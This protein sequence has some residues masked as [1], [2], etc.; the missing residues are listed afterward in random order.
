MA[1]KVSAVLE[2]KGR[3]VV[4]VA[5]RD[6]VASLVKVLSVNRIGAAPVVNADGRL[7]G[8]ISERDVIR[9]MAQHGD[10]VTALPVERLMTTEV[11]TCSPEDAIV[12]LMEVMTLQRIRHLPV[13]RNGALEGIVSIGDVVKQRLAEA[14]SELNELRSYISSGS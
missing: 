6:T 1:T 8:I 13:V 14:Q 9:G 7:A 4:T 3:N 10:S 5:P 11:R 2:S 12:E